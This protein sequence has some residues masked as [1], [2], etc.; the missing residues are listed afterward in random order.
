[1]IKKLGRWS[2]HLL[3]SLIQHFP[4]CREH[5]IRGE[6]TLGFLCLR[7]GQSEYP[8]LLPFS[9]FRD[10]PVRPVRA[11]YATSVGDVGNMCLLFLA[12]VVQAVQCQP[13]G[14]RDILV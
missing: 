3:S 1:M 10:G 14:D 7:M 12:W 13:P 2:G 9:W 8:T 5:V 11:R 4:L 6:L